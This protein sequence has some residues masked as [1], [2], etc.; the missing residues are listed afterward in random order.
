MCQRRLQLRT[1]QVI[2]L[3]LVGLMLGSAL[4]NYLSARTLASVCVV[5][6][7]LETEDGRLDL[8]ALDFIQTKTTSICAMPTMWFEM[9][10]I[11]TVDPSSAHRAAHLQRGPPCA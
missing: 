1:Y 2:A 9:L 6:R 8:I 7:V 5:E 10:T 4:L 11:E 3:F